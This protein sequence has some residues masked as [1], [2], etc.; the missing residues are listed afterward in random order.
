MWGQ[1]KGRMKDSVNGRKAEGDGHCR[2]GEGHPEETQSEERGQ[3][4][5]SL[6]YDGGI[7]SITYTQSI[8]KK[9]QEMW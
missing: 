9:G 8:R 3:G 7:S 2:E 5:G 4:E 6:L 1:G